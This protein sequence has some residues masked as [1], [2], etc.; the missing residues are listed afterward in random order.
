VVF[1][2]NADETPGNTAV[3]HRSGELTAG[4]YPND[5]KVGCK[6][7]HGGW[8]EQS[9][10][11]ALVFAA[12]D[13]IVAWN[14]RRRVQASES[15]CSGPE[16]KRAARSGRLPLDPGR[17]VA[18]APRPVSWSLLSARCAPE[19]RQLLGLVGRGFRP[20]K[21]LLNA[22]FLV[23]RPA[24]IDSPVYSYDGPGREALLSM[25]LLCC[26]T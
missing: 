5:I 20:T 10:D 24:A 12:V 17:L 18:S 6:R 14:C 13:R 4:V 25:R 15:G 19:T 9:K 11:G 16:R 23:S 3:Q 2:Y 26:P 22:V 8:F 7:S 1:V 21:H